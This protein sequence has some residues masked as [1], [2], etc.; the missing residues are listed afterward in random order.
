MT[1]YLH[2]LRVGFRDQVVEEI[3]LMGRD[4]LLGGAFGTAINLL[5][6][7][8]ETL[9]AKVGVAALIV[10]L[11][12]AEEG[13]ADRSYPS[14]NAR[15]LNR[16]LTVF[17]VATFIG[18]AGLTMKG[19]SALEELGRTGQMM[20]QVLQMSD[21]ESEELGIELFRER[22]WA[23]KKLSI[24]LFGVLVFLV[25]AHL[26]M[27]FGLKV[28]VSLV[29]RLTKKIEKINEERT[30]PSIVTSIAAA[31]AVFKL[32]TTANRMPFLPGVAILAEA[33][34][35][36]RSLEI[37]SILTTGGTAQ[38]VARLS[39]RIGRAPLVISAAIIAA[40]AGQAAR[41]TL[42]EVIED[43]AGAILSAAIVGIVG[44]FF[45]RRFISKKA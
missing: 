13:I 10:G 33:G 20:W 5:A 14:L 9:A 41:Y 39:V 17:N 28:A 24:E 8:K 30:G 11:M 37:A 25:T 31:L 42:E 26:V 16:A 35:A 12:A 32:S 45:F 1:T 43:K 27:V 19:M 23:A 29:S 38:A 40:A 15:K 2:G 21:Y 4:L 18:L 6:P 34:K 22:K 7:T 36:A 3:K 44:G